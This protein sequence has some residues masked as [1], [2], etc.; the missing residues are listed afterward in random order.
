[1]FAYFNN[2][3]Y[4]HAVRNAETLRELLGTGVR[5]G[6]QPGL[7]EWSRRGLGSQRMAAR[8]DREWKAL[9]ARSALDPTARERFSLACGGLI[10]PELRENPAFR[11]TTLMREPL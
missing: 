11:G 3:G 2:D 10:D 1:V 5:A 7:S 4:G 9:L 8:R 6:R